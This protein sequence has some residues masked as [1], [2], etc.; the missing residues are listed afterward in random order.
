MAG[1]NTFVEMADMSIIFSRAYSNEAAACLLTRTYFP[2]AEFQREKHSLELTGTL[3][4]SEIYIHGNNDE[5]KG[6]SGQWN[7]KTKFLMTKSSTA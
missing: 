6:Q 1:D 2:V 5:A 7:W 4:L 3:G